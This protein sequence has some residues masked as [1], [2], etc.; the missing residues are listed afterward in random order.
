MASKKRG[1]GRGLDAL[2]AD[3]APV[4][5]EENTAVIDEVFEKEEEVDSGDRV[6]Y[7]DIDDIKPNPNQ[8][9][10][11]F[12]V[13]RLEE[14]SQSIQDNGVIQPLVVQRKGSGYELVAGERRWRASRLAGLKKIP[15]L[16]REFD[17]KQNLIVTIIEN[18]QREYLDPIEEANGL[19]QMIHKFG[20]TQEQV[21]ESLGKS[22]AYIANS[23]RLL[24]L[25]EDVQKMRV[26]FV[27]AKENADTYYLSCMSNELETDK[28]GEEV[29]A[30]LRLQDQVIEDVKETRPEEVD[31][32]T[33]EL[34]EIDIEFTFEVDKGEQSRYY[35]LFTNDKQLFEQYLSY[36]NSLKSSN[37][38]QRSEV[39][40]SAEGMSYAQ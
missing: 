39:H 37:L 6:H 25:P 22:R 21:S 18:M 9:R 4:L 5:E 40:N 17:E 15:C 24:K 10:K 33:S 14:L 12:N 2:F 34:Y 20:F 19:Q 28:Y 13:K 27:L 7:I 26:S 11:K 8:P 36:V 38:I 35:T 32:E 1:L 3:A 16:I 30:L 23:V 31:W 29:E